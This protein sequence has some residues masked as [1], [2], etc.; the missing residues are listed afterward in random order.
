MEEQLVPGIENSSGV[1]AR[2]FHV[3]C[4]KRVAPD[5]FGAPIII[6]FKKPI[7]GKSAF[8][9]NKT[10]GKLLIKL[11]GN[12][13]K[14]FIGKKIKLE[15]ISVRNPRTEKIAASL[16]VRSKQSMLA[17]FSPSTAL[18]FKNLTNQIPRLPRVCRKSNVHRDPSGSCETGLCRHTLM[19]ARQGQRVHPRSLRLLKNAVAADL[20]KF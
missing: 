1:W 16:A 10:K 14:A 17:K 13:T 5:D 9:V 2:I 15:V 3:R 7:H 19:R 12:D 6:E 8:A 11:F 18:H 20:I 4:C